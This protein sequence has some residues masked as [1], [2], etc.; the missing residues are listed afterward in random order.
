MIYGVNLET[1][2]SGKALIK[3]I[4][5]TTTGKGE[6]GR[7]EFTFDNVNSVPHITYK[8]DLSWVAETVEAVQEFLQDNLGDYEYPSWYD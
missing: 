1:E 2:T 7:A 3:V 6:V 5:V 4:A 8:G